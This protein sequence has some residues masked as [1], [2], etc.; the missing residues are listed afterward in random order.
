MSAYYLSSNTTCVVVITQFLS[1]FKPFDLLSRASYVYVCVLLQVCIWHAITDYYFGHNFV[2]RFEV[3]PCR[4]QWLSVCTLVCN[5]HNYGAI[6]FCGVVILIHT[7][8]FHITYSV[9]Y[10][11]SV[12]L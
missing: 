3:Y 8:I 6:V 5:S 4:S 1:R 11:E 12:E 10:K 2:S 7:M 9:L